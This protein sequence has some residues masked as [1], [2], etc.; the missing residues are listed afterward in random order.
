MLAAKLRLSAA[1]SLSSKSMP[2]RTRRTPHFSV[3][4]ESMAQFIALPALNCSPNAGRWA[5]V[6][7]AERK[8]PEDMVWPLGSLFIRLG[9]SGAAENVVSPRRWQIAIEIHYR[10][11]WKTESRR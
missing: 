3:A 6:H 5:V 2:L 11:R 10:L 4:E 1:I 7:P 9:Q 8:S